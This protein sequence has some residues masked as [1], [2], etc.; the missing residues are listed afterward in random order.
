VSKPI[1]FYCLGLVLLM[2][3]AAS[4]QQK[5]SP[6]INKE[7]FMHFLGNF[8][9]NRELQLERT[10]FPLL[11]ISLDES[12]TKEIRVYI[13]KGDWKFENVFIK[14]DQESY[15]Q[16]YDSFEKKMRDTDE[17]VV[18][19][20]GIGNGIYVCYYFQRIN[21]KWYLVKKEDHST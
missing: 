3:Y 9:L 18:V 12:F 13:K 10:K 5:S 8:S 16:V 7:E 1:R 14:P 20:Q 21:G 17:R 6:Q 15:R 2:T 11:Y 19:Q 4:G